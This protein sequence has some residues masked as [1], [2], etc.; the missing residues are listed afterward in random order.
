MKQIVANRNTRLES[1]DGTH[2]NTEDVR[3]LTDEARRNKLSVLE[4]ALTVENY[5]SKM[6]SHFFFSRNNDRKAKFDEMI[7]NSE[8]CSFATKRKLLNQIINTENLLQGPKKQ[9]FD[10]SL[11]KVISCRNTF[12]HGKLSCDGKT[13]W[14][15]YF[16]GQPRKQELTDTYLTDVESQLSYASQCCLEL[17]QKMG[18]ISVNV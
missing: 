2:I 7:I 14:L 13:V 5:L 15:S 6:I 8:W 17:A 3:R 4:G 9:E 18:A 12:T 16:E 11:R 1:P 10:D